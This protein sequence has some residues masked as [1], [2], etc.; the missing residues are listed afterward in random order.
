[1]T[2]KFTNITEATS[3]LSD[4]FICCAGYEPRAKYI[5]S[6]YSENLGKKFAFGYNRSLVLNYDD[7]IEALEKNGVEI[8][9]DLDDAAFVS[10]LQS[11]VEQIKSGKLNTDK[12]KEQRILR[13]TVDIS[14]FDR[15]RMAEIVR[16]L[17]TLQNEV[18]STK[19]TYLYS[20]ARFSPP[21]PTF[22][23]N[24]V[25]GPIHQ[26]FRGTLFNTT[27]PLALVAGLG[28]EQNKVLGAAEYLTASKIVT[29]KPK[30][31][32]TEFGEWVDRANK[33][34]FAEVH[35]NDQHEYHIA[36]PYQTLAKLDSIIRG[37]KSEYNV[38]MLP[39]GPKLF[40]LSCLFAQ[41][42]NPSTSVWRVSPAEN[43]IPANITEWGPV[44]GM[45]VDSR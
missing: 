11:I 44:Y 9:R 2:L 21:S 31:A 28:Y 30:S 1:M 42:L 27:K 17:T 37:L 12:S 38:V 39:L 45:T 25:A 33:A 35:S 10:K 40:T 5:C 43:T 7:N 41:K 18:S 3:L 36:N 32:Q 19:I 34:L 20:I 8:F 26:F 15:F 13:V 29:L 4:F 14:S 23:P 6:R 16:A 24:K 22:A